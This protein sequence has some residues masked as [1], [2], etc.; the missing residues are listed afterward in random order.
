MKNL[1][2]V[3]ALLALSST[4]FSQELAT[5]REPAGYAFFPQRGLIT[6]KA[7]GW[8]K[9]RISQ[10]LFTLRKMGEA[11]YDI[12][13]VDATTQVHSAKADG[14]VVKLLRNGENEMAFILFYP[15]STI[16]I[17]TFWRDKPGRN[18]LG[19]LTSRGGDGMVQYK[20]SVM[21]ANC[22]AITFITVPMKAN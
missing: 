21:V 10:G 3:L 19:I 20:Q 9:D 14:A 1:T 17:Y 5:C 8:E 18:Q 15:G 16:E 4:A 6:T 11:E 7:A 2:A 12:L 22:S 13:Y